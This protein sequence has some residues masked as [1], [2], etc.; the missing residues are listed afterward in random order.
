MLLRQLF[1]APRTAVVAFGRMNPPT[2][3]HQKLV[4][5]IKSLPGDHYVFLSQSQKPKTDPLSFEDKLRYAKFFFPNVT[6][7]HPEVKTIIQAMQK[8]EQL[9]Y[10]SV[11]YVAGSDRVDS[12][13]KL[14]NQYNGQA[15]KSGNIPYSFKSI[16]IVSA[17]ERDPDAD[18][19]EGM[20]AS[21]MRQAAVDNDLESFKQGVPQQEL[22]DEMFAAVKQGMGVKDEATAEGWFSGD[23]L[24]A[25]EWLNDENKELWQKAEPTTK[26]KRLVTQLKKLQR[27][28]QAGL[29]D[30]ANQVITKE[31]GLMQTESIGSDINF[32]G[33][34]SD[35]EKK[36]KDKK[37]KKSTSLLSKLKN[38]VGIDESLFEAAT[39]ADADAMIAAIK[40]FQQAAGLKADGIVGPDTRAKAGEMM[41]D[42][43]QA[44][45]VTTL[46][47]AIK[48]FQTKAGITADGK[49]G[50][51]TMGAVN[52][53]QGLD[54]TTGKPAPAEPATDPN[55]KAGVDGP[56]GEAPAV[57]PQTPADAT[58]KAGTA[59]TDD[60]NAQK[61]QP[62]DPTKTTP[63]NNQQAAATTKPVNTAA[64][65]N[66][67]DGTQP[68]EEPA[69]TANDKDGLVQRRDELRRKEANS[70]LMPDEEK[71][72]RQIQ[73]KIS[74]VPEPKADPAAATEPK[75]DP[76]KPNSGSEYT[77]DGKPVSRDE[78]EKK[79]GKDLSGRTNDYNRLKNQI[80]GLSKKASDEKQ[81]WTQQQLDDPKSPYYR[82][83]PADK[84][85]PKYPKELTAIDDKYA[86]EAKKLQA[87]ADKLSSD[88]EVKKMIDAGGDKFD[89]ALNG[90]DDD[91][92][93]T[94][95]KPKGS[96]EVEK[97][98]AKIKK[99]KDP[100]ADDPEGDAA[101]DKELDGDDDDKEGTT[102]TNTSSKDGNTT[103]TSSST[104]TVTRSGGTSTTKKV[105]GGGST[106]RF[107]KQMMDGPDTAGLRAEKKDLRKQM[108]AFGDEFDKNNPKAGRF[109]YLDDPEYQKL[110]A[111]MDEYEGLAGKIAKSQE[112][113]HPSGVVD[114]DGNIKYN[115]KDGS[116]DGE[117]F[118]PDRKKK[119]RS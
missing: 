10:D 54:A 46:Q 100:F 36:K 25:P 56:G 5:K 93:N 57:A 20:S 95:E 35:E 22:A 68:V 97:A 66:D 15:D 16:K 82:G 105:S 73:D 83:V 115:T 86:A 19:A 72:L 37:K 42:P 51:Q 108:R 60:P 45:V 32:P 71:E 7:G 62:E 113:R 87:Q 8:L 39:R 11:V 6:V 78:Y 114:K 21:K 74:T 55:A 53:A 99:Q 109:D 98:R 89:R 38:I 58:A 85:D 1:E 119:S 52:T 47:G 48:G 13:T 49:V 61:A 63:V 70:F 3:G 59:Q 79:F 69:A 17:G 31:L 23:P 103:R 41:K 80:Q 33:F 107:S 75:A 116:W 88:P 106:I 90:D 9:G 67:K 24:P 102:T 30:E 44:K 12:F 64:T 81:Q 26:D 94:I 34:D 91:F 29:V 92:F 104:S 118:D 77:L 4:D 43:A 110:E 27:F 28:I 50:P 96:P 40:T 18:G 14:L 65:A 76:E 112:V 84:R 2:I 111:Q 117:Q 101:F